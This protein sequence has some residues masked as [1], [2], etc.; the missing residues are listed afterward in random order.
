M[1]GLLRHQLFHRIDCVEPARPEIFVV[2]GVFADG[3]GE[4]HAIEFNNLLLRRWGEIALLVEDVVEGQQP[5]VLFQQQLPPS[6]STAAFTA[7]LP[8]PGSRQ[9]PRRPGPP[10]ARSRVAAASFID[11]QT[12]AGQ[13]A[14]FL[15]KIGWRIPADRKLGKHGEPRSVG[16]GALAD[17][18]D[19]FEIPGEIPDRGVD[20]GERDL[21]SSSLIWQTKQP[22]EG[23]P[24]CVREA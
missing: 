22:H 18:N 6:S 11:G 19:L 17:C 2:P 15:K 5:L 4:P 8:G 21:H 9:G 24:V 3:D 10:S 14:R 12:A 13:E 23:G 20:L 16:G 7:G 1:V